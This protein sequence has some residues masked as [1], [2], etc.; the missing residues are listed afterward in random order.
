MGKKR[1][2]TKDDVCQ[3]VKEKF[4]GKFTLVNFDTYIDC[5]QKVEV[6]CNDCGNVFTQSITGL[7]YE[8]HTHYCNICKSKEVNDNFIKRLTSLYGDEYTPLEIYHDCKTKMLIKH[9]VCGSVYSTTGDYLFNGNH[10][11]P[12]CSHRKGADKLFKTQKEIE[13]R[14]YEKC[15]N[16]YTVIGKYMGYN[17]KITVIHNKCG[18]T[19]DI[20][21]SSLLNGKGCIYCGGKAP[22][23]TQIYKEELKQRYGN[24]YSLLS[25]YKNAK[26]KITI[27]HN[28]CGYVWDIAPYSA[29]HH[30]SCPNCNKSKGETV[31]A[32]ILN[33]NQIEYIPQYCFSDCKDKICL[34]F[35][36][37]IPS[38][39][40]VIEYDGIGHYQAVNWNGCTNDVANE[41]FRITQL[42]DYIKND[43]CKSNN[44]EL[45][46][47]PYWEYDNIENI[48]NEK[49]KEVTRCQSVASV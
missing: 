45:L 8:N 17:K 33:K 22:M 4:N 43:Y 39:N 14:I 30:H 49:I 38:L 29:I 36:F 6:K 12:K 27:R 48:L 42:H 25:E 37:Y 11:C 26:T 1:F 19:I 2:L 20:P 47:I 18:R 21:V 10:A 15:G 44:I 7:L 13:T 16:E 35:D 46:R 32:K 40:T 24:E 23:T 5:K 28:K 9:N 31:I 34:P 41:T 3:R